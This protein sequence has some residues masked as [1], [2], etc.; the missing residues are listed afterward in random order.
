[1]PHPWW[2]IWFALSLPVVAY[3]VHKMNNIVKE[4]LIR[5]YYWLC[6]VLSYSFSHHK[7]WSAKAKGVRP[8]VCLYNNLFRSQEMVKIKELL[9]G[10]LY[11]LETCLFMC[12]RSGLTHPSLPIWPLTTHYHHHLNHHRLLD[13]LSFLSYQTLCSTEDHPSS[14]ALQQ[15]L[16]SLDW[17]YSCWQSAP[18]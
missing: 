16:S 12:M 1:M 4:Q 8:Q 14:I 15:K 2:E 13:Q 17:L 18:K 11:L 9:A 5:Y 6:L 7:T 3:G 10:C